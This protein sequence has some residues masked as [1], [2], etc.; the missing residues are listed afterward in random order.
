MR[1]FWVLTAL[2]ALIA[3]PAVAQQPLIPPSVQYKQYKETPR[4]KL[5]KDYGL[6]A[7]GTRDATLPQQRT[8][9][10]LK[11]APAPEKPKAFGRVEGF[12]AP[13][14][15]APDSPNFFNDLP[16]FANADTQANDTP[17]FFQAP[18]DITLP[19]V[20]KPLSA[21]STMD[22]PQFTTSEG[23]TTGVAPPLGVQPQVDPAR[24]SAPSHPPPIQATPPHPPTDLSVE[25]LER[26]KGIEPSCAAW[27]AAVLPLNYTRARPT[28]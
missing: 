12:N 22:T 3:G 15:Q 1:P 13:D 4:E 20:R 17:D 23:V 16:S 21:F 14:A 28:F 24:K 26:V 8:Q 10:P 27:E 11:L 9:A 25:K 7:L 19:N 18:P 2:A 6:P 5:D